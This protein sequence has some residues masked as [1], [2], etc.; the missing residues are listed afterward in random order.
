MSLTGSIMLLL[1]SA[2]AQSTSRVPVPLADFSVPL[3]TFACSN[4]SADDGI[5]G[6]WIQNDSQFKKIRINQSYGEQGFDF[7]IDNGVRSV[8]FAED[9]DT[10]NWLVQAQGLREGHPLSVEAKIIVSG[11]GPATAELSVTLDREMHQET[12]ILMPP[13][14]GGFSGVAQ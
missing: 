11:S 13:P 3:L 1:A 5:W 6:F 12:C 9:V 7:V 8:T 14:P 4:K 2:A 10:K